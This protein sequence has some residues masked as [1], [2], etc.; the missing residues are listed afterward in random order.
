MPYESG[1]VSV[2]LGAPIRHFGDDVIPDGDVRP[3][4]H[5]QLLGL[6][7]PG[8]HLIEDVP[9]VGF[10]ATEFRKKQIWKKLKG[11]HLYCV[12]HT[13]DCDVIRATWYPGELDQVVHWLETVGV[14]DR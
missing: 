9:G 14:P 2:K 13:E 6:L 1:L 7:L 4:A 12:A 11:K 10:L 5:D 3:L 8:P